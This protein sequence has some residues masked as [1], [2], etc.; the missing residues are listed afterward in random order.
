M[1]G[2][3]FA[4]V[5]VNPNYTSRHSFYLRKLTPII[6]GAIGFQWGYKNQSNHLM[7]TMLKMNDYLPLEVRRTLES[8]DYRHMACF[9][10]SEQGPSRLFDPITG[11]SLS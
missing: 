9:N 6:F 7:N 5:V 3:I 11:K 1:A 8:K 10:Y 4:G 2:V